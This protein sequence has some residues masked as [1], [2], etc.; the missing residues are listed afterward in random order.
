LLISIRMAD[1]SNERIA[2]IFERVAD[3]LE[4]QRASPHRVRAWR[5]GAGT[6]RAAPRPLADLFR[7]EGLAGLHALPHIGRGLA[8][9]IVEVLRR[10][11]ARVLERLEGEVTAEDL[12]ADLPGIGPRLARRVHDTLGVETLEEIEAAARAGRLAA[13]EGFGPKRIRAVREV[14]ATRLG[15]TRRPART[16]AAPPVGLILEMDRRYRELGAAGR[17]HRIAPRRQNPSGAA[18]LPILHEE[19]AGWSFTVLFSNTPLAHELGRTHDWVVVY[20]ERDDEEGRAT[21]V[22]ETRGPLA[23]QRVVRGRERETAAELGA[24]APA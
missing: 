13:V 14:L 11:R 19:R 6:L 22:T 18:W 9:V 21:V 10:G 16:G 24:P 23:G 7:E 5:E 8:S 12:F 3:L 15:R 17:L 1:P 2:A 20:H 4:A